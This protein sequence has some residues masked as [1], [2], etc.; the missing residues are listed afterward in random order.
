MSF[1]FQQHLEYFRKHEGI[2]PENKKT[3]E[4]FLDECAAEGLSEIRQSKYISGFIAILTRY[5]P[6][7]LKLHKV[8]EADLKKIVAAVNRSD[9]SEESK[10][11]FKICLKKFCKL[12]SGGRYPRK[13]EFI[14]TSGKKT[15]TVRKEDL[16]TKEEIYRII[17]QMRCIRDRAFL[18]VLYESGARTGELLKARLG[19][20][21]FNGTGDFIRLEGL[22][23]TPDRDIQLVDA[24]YYL[25]EW[26]RSHPAGKDP[27]SV[28]DPSAPLW[29]KMENFSCE[30]CGK[31]MMKHTAGKACASYKPLMIEPMTH[32]TICRSFERAC[33]RANIKKRSYRLYNL[34]HT[35]ITEASSFLKSEHLNKFA[36][37]KPGSGQSQIYVHLNSEDVN[38]AIR[39]RYNLGSE[40]KKEPVLCKI[41]WHQNEPGRTEC[42]KCRRP[43]TVVTTYKVNQVKD[44]LKVLV[45]LQEQGKLEELVKVA[46]EFGSPT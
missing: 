28:E 24:G 19:D 30:T 32:Q 27:Y 22:K 6:P 34:R 15:T 26:M 2:S 43:L 9:L 35:R 11:F 37:W 40:P 38:K 18:V 46:H 12:E 16:Y 23:G 25:K 5:A 33:Q 21:E 3:V 4:W 36:G 42:L 45:E 14:T 41:C 1:N 13:V 7:S 29:V 20:V 44:A 8:S 17:S 10:R 31:S 39:E